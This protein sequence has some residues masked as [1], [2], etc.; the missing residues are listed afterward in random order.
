MDGNWHHVVLTKS[1]GSSLAAGDFH[2]YVDGND[3]ALDVTCDSLSSSYVTSAEFILAS[4]DGG[5]YELA[6]KIDDV[7]VYDDE[8]SQAEVTAIYNSGEPVDNRLLSSSGNLVGY[9]RM[10]DNATSPTIPDDS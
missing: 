2:I 10:G 5:G 7:S 9:W 1:T 4:N 8:L 3:E 6:G